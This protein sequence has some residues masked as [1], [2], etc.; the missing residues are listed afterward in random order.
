[1]IT[2]PSSRLTTAPSRA[3]ARQGGLSQWLQVVGRYET[4]TIGT[5]PVDDTLTEDAIVRPGKPPRAPGDPSGEPSDVI[6]GGTKAEL[7]EASRAT[8]V[9]LDPDN[10]GDAVKAAREA[11]RRS[12]QPKRRT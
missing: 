3:A 9:R 10:A 8:T 6:I 5:V 12:A 7:E 1:M 2:I 11:A 4:S